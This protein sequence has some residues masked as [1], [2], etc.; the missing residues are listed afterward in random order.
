MGGSNQSS[1]LLQFA[2][3]GPAGALRYQSTAKHAVFVTQRLSG[4]TYNITALLRKGTRRTS[5]SVLVTFTAA[6]PAQI[7]IKC[8][9]GSLCQ[10][11]TNGYLAG[12]SARLSLLAMCRE[13]GSQ[14]AV[15]YIWTIS[16]ADYRFQ[17]RWRPLQ[18]VELAHNRS[19]GLATK[20]LTIFP[21]L[22]QVYPDNK[23]YRV[24]CS[25][26]RPNGYVGWAATRIKVNEPP[27]SG[28]CSVF[29]KVQITSKK[30]AGIGEVK[31][32]VSLPEGAHWMCFNNTIVTAIIDYFGSYTQVPIDT[33]QVFRLG[34]EEILNV[35]EAVEVNLT[36]MTQEG[37]LVKAVQT[38]TGLSDMLN[39]YRYQTVNGSMTDKFAL[40]FGQYYSHSNETDTEGSCGTG[41]GFPAQVSCWCRVR[42]RV[43]VV[44]VSV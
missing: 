29:P 32:N 9:G 8:T 33:V 6:I 15:S 10:Q 36:I 23:V 19:R 1:Y 25:V 34:V 11:L 16:V 24:N 26:T 28:Q 17:G 20:E 42:G 14:E 37:V 44:S 12:E 2:T 18:T 7:D 35:T 3:K 41:L 38:A 39:S 31:L 4:Q 13:C 43:G 22:F 27:R 5:A 21:T 30:S 40:G